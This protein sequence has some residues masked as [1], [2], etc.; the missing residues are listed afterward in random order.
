[1]SMAASTY[2][3]ERIE[4]DAVRGVYLEAQGL[5]VLRF[6]NLQVLTE[7]DA[8]VEMIRRRVRSPRTPLHDKGR[9]PML[10][11]RET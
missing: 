10:V 5:K 2:E 11:G 9:W 4:N 8:V 6:N 7:T 1:M 3:E